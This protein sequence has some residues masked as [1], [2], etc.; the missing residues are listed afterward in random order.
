MKKNTTYSKQ[1]I[2][3]ADYIFKNPDEKMKSVIS[4]F[5]GKFRK[6]SR[7][8][9][10]YIKQAKEYNK[11]RLDRTEK[12]KANTE[13]EEIKKAAKSNILSRSK[14][15]EILSKIAEGSARKI[16]DELEIPTDG[17]RIRAIQQLAKMEG[18][19]APEKKE[20]TGKDGTNLIPIN[21][22]SREEIM[23]EI[24]QIRTIR[25]DV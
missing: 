17:D 2:E 13:D 19:E 15:L 24:K 18:W 6:T 14:S 20:I 10:N 3:I 23:A 12:I 8:I 7:T 1:V 9:E 5:V 11:S 25:N 16:G 22:M 4:V 21:E